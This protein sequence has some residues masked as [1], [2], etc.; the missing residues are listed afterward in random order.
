MDRKETKLVFYDL[1]WNQDEI[2]QIGAVCED[3]VF[4]QCIRPSGQMDPSVRKKI[5]LDVRMD[6]SGERQVYDMVKK[7]FLHTV[8]PEEGF[9]RYDEV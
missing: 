8:S 3:S 9:D 2:I 4:S 6:E 7:Q 1:E 5:K